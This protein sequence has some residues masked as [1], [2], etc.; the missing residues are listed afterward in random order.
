M[1]PEN[2]TKVLDHFNDMF[3]T[4]ESHD[5]LLEL[6]QTKLDNPNNYDLGKIVAEKIQEHINIA[7]ND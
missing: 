5:F 4:T 2:Q 3:G 7:L 1:T 6:V